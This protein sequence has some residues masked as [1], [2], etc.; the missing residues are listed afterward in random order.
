LILV[1]TKVPFGSK[2]RSAGK[3]KSIVY[4]GTAEFAAAP[5]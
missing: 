2:R 1:K 5:R 4:Y 3:R